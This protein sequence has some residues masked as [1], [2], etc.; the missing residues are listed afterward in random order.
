MEN[1]EQLQV[2]VS[3]IQ[4]TRQQ[5]ATV[6]AQILELEATSQAVSN[7]PEDLA[8]HQQ[9]GGVLI[10]VSDRKALLEVLAKDV[11]TLKS[12]M[13]RLQNREVELVSSYEELKKVLEG[14]N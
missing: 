6:N 10:E 13:E 5:M 1:M 14:S 2:V 8:L 7:Q 12:H 9:L 4:S 11:E 3:E